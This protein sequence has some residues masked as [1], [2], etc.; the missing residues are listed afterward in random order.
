MANAQKKKKGTMSG[1]GSEM[2]TSV[3]TGRMYETVVRSGQVLDCRHRSLADVFEELDCR[4]FSHRFKEMPLSNSSVGRFL[5]P[6]SK[7]VVGSLVFHHYA[8]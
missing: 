7:L 4:V 8:L 5:S 1:L 3:Y 2:P 6:E